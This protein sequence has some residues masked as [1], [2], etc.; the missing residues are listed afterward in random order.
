MTAL[1]S[2]IADIALLVLAFVADVIVD[3]T[4]LIVLALGALALSIG[5][6]AWPLERAK[7]DGG[8]RGF[9]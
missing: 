1:G 9:I 8:G 6:I 3:S 2:S 4:P 5:V 7:K